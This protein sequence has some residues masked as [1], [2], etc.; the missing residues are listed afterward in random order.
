MFIA[1]LLCISKLNSNAA[2]ACSE[3]TSSATFKVLIFNCLILNINLFIFNLFDVKF[4]FSENH[5]FRKQ[6]RTAVYGPASVV[7]DFKLTRE[8]DDLLSL[9]HPA[10]E[11]TKMR[12]PDKRYQINTVRAFWGTW[13]ALAM[14]LGLDHSGRY[15][16]K[17]C[18]IKARLWNKKF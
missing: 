10:E 15:R 17:I 9:R 7:L 14:Y 3:G 16:T 4:L 6:K 18:E 13:N 11:Y 12:I 1:L 8:N 2:Q 5:I